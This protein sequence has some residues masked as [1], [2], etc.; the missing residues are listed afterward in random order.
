MIK[1]KKMKIKKGDTVLVLAGKDKGKTGEV[2]RVLAREDRAV[3]S[4]INVAKI[5]KKPTKN[6]AGQIVSVEKAIH[7]SNISLMENNR[8]AKV[9]FKI[10]NG[11]K[12]RYF[13]KS[14]NVVGN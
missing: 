6:S 13:K 10:E 12:V 8:A 1:T 11:K 3:V 4:G 9:G 14:G 5:H 7:I 2:L